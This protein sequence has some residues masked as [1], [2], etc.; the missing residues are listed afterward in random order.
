MDEVSFKLNMSNNITGQ[1]YLIIDEQS[2]PEKGW[3]DFP[4]IVLSWWLQ[5]LENILNSPLGTSYE[6]G[7]MDGPF[8]VR[9]IKNE[10]DALKLTFIK[11]RLDGEME[12]FTTICSIK[13]F[14]NS[15]V[16]AAAK[17]VNFVE[18]TKR[19]STDDIQE[20]KKLCRKVSDSN[21]I[22]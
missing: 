12:L 17:A 19:W 9:G 2:F 15:L 4:V 1:I 11:D 5:S 16:S 21:F 14:K 8:L 22:C 13:Q 7:F 6:F 10:S 20:L 3:Y 18:Q